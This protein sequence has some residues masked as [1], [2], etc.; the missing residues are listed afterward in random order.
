MITSLDTGLRYD[1]LIFGY[2]HSWNAG[3][4]IKKTMWN[5]GNDWRII[6]KNEVSKVKAD[7]P[8]YRN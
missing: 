8:Y 7:S 4:R 5:H 3:D 1:R 2:T 6:E